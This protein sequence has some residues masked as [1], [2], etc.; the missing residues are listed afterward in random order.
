MRQENVA[1]LKFI[2]KYLP[3]ITIFIIIIA[4]TSNNLLAK[5]YG[6]DQYTNNN[7]LPALLSDAE[8]DWAE[9]IEED[10][11]MVNEP[12]AMNQFSEEQG[13]LREVVIDTPFPEEVYDSEQITNTSPDES[14]LVQVSPQETQ[15]TRTETVVYTVQTGDVLGKIAEKF[16]LSTNTI[17]WANNLTWNSTIKPGQ[18]LTILPSSGIEHQVKSGDTILAIAKKYQAEA[19]KIISENK[20]AD[21]SD[22]KS[23][24][25]LFIP[26]GIKP[27]QIVSSYQPKTSNNPVYSDEKVAPASSDSGTKLLWPV[28]S[29]RITQYYSLVHTGLDIGDKTG[30]PIYAAEAGKVE[31]AGWN[32][33]GYG[34]YVIINHGNGLKTVYGHA[35]KLLV[36]TGD[37]VSRGETIA[38]IGSTGRSTGPHLHFEV[39]VNNV[40]KNPLNYIK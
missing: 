36:K 17:L 33:G 34:N 7:L 40:R 20:L 27:T 19:D 3:R 24:D 14:S 1:Y 5:T 10:A 35:S 28:L 37:T 31:I 25:T 30:N 22:I 6:I 39:R 11:L 8:A 9:L 32:A 15:N 12:I 18:K 29:Q 16:G 26:N 21:A 2:K 4:V 38:L 13:A 23:G